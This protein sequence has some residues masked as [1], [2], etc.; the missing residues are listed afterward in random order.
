MIHLA[1][2]NILTIE[3]FTVLREEAAGPKLRGGPTMADKM[4]GLSGLDG[5]LKRRPT[6]RR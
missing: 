2:S 3:E 5:H 6:H 4:Q 1:S